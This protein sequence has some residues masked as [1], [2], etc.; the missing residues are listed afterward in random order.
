M[1]SVNERSIKLVEKMILDPEG[2]KVEVHNI[3]GANVIDCGVNVAGSWRAAKLMTEILFGGLNEVTFETFPEKI[4]GIYYNSVHVYSDHVVLQ[5]AGCN[6]S[7]WELR[8]GKYAPVLAGPGRTLA[9]KEGDW[10]SKYSDYQDKYPKAVLTVEQGTM[11]TEDAVKDLIDAV[12]IEPKD[13]YI[14]VA[15]SGSIA[16]SVQVSARII[17][18]ILHHV[19]CEV[20]AQ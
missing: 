7:G 11:L 1:I 5:Q 19:I 17:E 8:P 13:I 15:A 4:D 20:F 14:L 3:C 12:G 9:R 6:I 2:Y 10:F 18:Q 16:C